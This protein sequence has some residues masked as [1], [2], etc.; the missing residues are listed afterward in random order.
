MPA[1]PTSGSSIV[2]VTGVSGFVGAH[3][4]HAYLQRGFSVRGTAR[5]L[6]KGAAIRAIFDEEFPGKFE[7]VAADVEKAEQLDAAAVGVDGIAHVASPITTLAPGADPQLLIS[8]AVNGTLNVLKSAAKAGTVKRVVITGSVRAILHPQDAPYT[9]SSRDWNDYAVQQVERLGAGASSDDKYA[10]SKTLAERAANEWV[11]QNKPA[12]DVAHILPTWVFGPILQPYTS[13]DDMFTTP[14]IL[15]DVFAVPKSGAALGTTAGSFV[16]VHDVA[17]AHVDAHTRAEL[18]GARLILS[19]ASYVTVQQ[20][21][22]AYWSLP[23]PERPKLPFEVPKGEPGR[24]VD[25]VQDGIL[26]YETAEDVLGWSFKPIDV[27][28]RDSLAD[29]VEK[30]Y[31]A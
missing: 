19:T 29:V 2:L 12:F 3:V 15:F 27:V 23:E 18:G 21:Y 10:A 30:L 4:A 28:V 22:D 24:P 1:I 31:K 11:A 16:H 20:Y 5:T 7:L 9:F 14:R 17:R 26:K 6:A 8:P 25:E 13:L